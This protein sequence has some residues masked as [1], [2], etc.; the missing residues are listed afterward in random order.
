MSESELRQFWNDRMKD[1]HDIQRSLS[2]SDRELARQAADLLERMRQL[3]SQRSLQDPQEAARL[4]SS[5]IQGFR[6]LELK[7]GLK[8]QE[9][10][11]N[12]Q[13]FNQEE[14]PLEYRKAV[15]EY[16][17]SLARSKGNTGK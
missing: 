4:Q 10:K 6:A 13:L 8:L 12:L 9:R 7:M 14:V 17:K 16:Y 2:G 1:A 5:I 15:E 3:D 11:A